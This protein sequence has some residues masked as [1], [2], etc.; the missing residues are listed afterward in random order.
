MKPSERT[1]ALREAEILKKFDHPNIVHYRE[2]FSDNR[3][4]FI[5]MEYANSSDLQ[6]LITKAKQQGKLLEE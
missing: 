2:A 1:D 6:N 5:V 3:N 4:L